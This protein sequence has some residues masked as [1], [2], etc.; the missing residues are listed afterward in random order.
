MTGLL[1]TLKSLPTA[2]NKDI[3]ESVEPLL[4]CVKTVCHLLKI[5]LGV[6]STLKVNDLRM[7][8][9]LTT[10]MLA[11]DVADYL[12][13]KGVPF[14]DTHHIAGVVVKKAEGLGTSIDKLTLS[15]LKEFST[16]FEADIKEVFDYEKSVERRRAL[17]GT[18]NKTVCIYV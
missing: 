1:A 7:R 17:G 11:T 18:S 16:G 2:Y 13:R 10:D 9:A 12:V 8:A 4:D 6:L 14:R 5:M 15:E 3:Q